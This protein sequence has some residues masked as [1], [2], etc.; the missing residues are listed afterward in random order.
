MKKTIAKLL[1]LPLLLSTVLGLSACGKQLE[2]GEINTILQDALQTTAQKDI[3]YWKETTVN[4]KNS[5]YRQ[6][7]LFAELDDD[8][9]AILDA[10]GEYTNYKLQIVETVN[11][12][13]TLQVFCGLSPSSNGGDAQN[14]LYTETYDENGDAQVQIE[15]MEVKNYIHSAA[16]EPY[17]PATLLQELYG[18]TAQD[19]DFSISDAEASTD[20]F[21]TSLIFAPT[22]EYLTRYRRTHGESSM[23]DGAKKVLIEIAYGRISA[24]VVYVDEAVEG[25]SLTVENERYKLQIVYLGPKFDMPSYDK[26]NS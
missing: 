11:Q 20:V 19:M 10:D 26:N 13:Q 2:S 5:T 22:E 25:S 7:N 15:P 17:L 1:V 18:L 21:V 24:V 16:F 23:F 3:F 9:E 12:E 8:G 14:V 4:G 6:V